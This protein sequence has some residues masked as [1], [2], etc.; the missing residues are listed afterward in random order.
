MS[1][2]RRPRVFITQPVADGAIARLKTAARVTVNA[3]AS[4]VLPRRALVEAVRRS[5]ILFCLLH[6]KIDAGVIAAN[7]KLRMIAAMSVTPSH[8]DVAEA[9]ARRIPVTV[10]PVL[11][12]AATAD[13]CFGLMLAIARRMIE[14]DRLVRGG[15]FPGAQSAYLLGA[16]VFGKTLGLIGGGGKIGRA[17]AHRAH[18]F[19]MRVLYWAPRRRPRRD[20][21]AARLTY[22]P[23]DRLLQESDF[24]SLHSPLNDETH[25]QIGARE[26]GLMKKTA[27]FINT[28]RGPIVDE[29]ALVRALTRNEIAGAGLDVF[30]FEPKV[31]PQLRR[32]PNVV[33]TPHLGSAV[34]D[35]REAM[36]NLVVD[37]IVAFL[38]GKKLPNCVNPEVFAL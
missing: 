5:D 8:I 19:N 32:L 16:P 15:R 20:E 11:Q 3:D 23:L 10:I 12:T 28:A 31:S 14:G 2:T 22:V 36:A 25:H 7:P 9:T 4:R 21:R 26:F 13:L 34:G 6:D 37:R 35:A 33:L 1:A 24:V 17:V 29:A 30:E 27:Y 18:G 38:H